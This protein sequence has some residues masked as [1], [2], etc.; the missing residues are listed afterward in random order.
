MTFRGTEE[1]PRAAARRLGRSRAVGKGHDQPLFFS[2]LLE[3]VPHGS[4][5]LFD[6]SANRVH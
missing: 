5:Q 1:R 6:Q 3:P 4:H 2:S